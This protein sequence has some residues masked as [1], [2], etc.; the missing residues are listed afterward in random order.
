MS[1]VGEHGRVAIAFGKKLLKQQLKKTLSL[2]W[3]FQVT[4]A[5]Q[6]SYSDF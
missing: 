5:T 1:L 3:I 2:P 6:V 4:E